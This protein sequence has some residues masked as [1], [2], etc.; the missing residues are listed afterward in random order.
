MGTPEV[1]GSISSAPPATKAFSDTPLIDCLAFIKFEV[2]FRIDTAKRRPREQISDSP[3]CWAPI[4]CLRSRKA[5]RS[6]RRPSEIL[7][8]VLKFS[9]REIRW[10]NKGDSGLPA[11]RRQLGGKFLRRIERNSARARPSASPRI[12]RDFILR[13]PGVDIDR[14]ALGN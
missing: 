2:S 11:P 5:R 9:D 3:M 10:W 8:F 14:G 12:Y 1:D 7:L 4:V 13:F 6:S